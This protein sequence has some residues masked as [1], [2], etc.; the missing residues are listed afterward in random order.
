MKTFRTIL[1]VTWKELAL[2]ARD[3]GNL[4]IMFLLPLLLSVM[5]SAANSSVNAEEGVAAI[6]LHVALV[7][8]D[9]GDFGREVVNAVEAIDELDIQRFVDL[10]E[11]EAE[12]AEGELSAAIH[13]PADFSAS[14]NAY[15]PTQVTVIVDPAQPESASIV[16]GIMNQVVDEVTIWGEVQ[17]GIRSVF[18]ESGILDNI[19]PEERRG[20]EAM[21]LGVIMT[22]LGEMR[23]SPLI[24]VISEDLEGEVSEDWL[25]AFLAYIFSG[26]VVMFI[27]F[28]VPMTSES[29]LKEREVGTLRRLIAAPIPATSVITGKL[30]AYMVLPCLQAILLFGVASIFFGVWLG[31]SPIALVVLTLIT[32]ATAASFGL[33]IASFAKSASQAANLGTAAGFILAIVAG[34]VPIGS[35]AFTRTGGFISILARIAPQAHALEGYLKLLSDGEGFVAILPELGILIAFTLVFLTISTRRFRYV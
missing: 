29:I 22:R 28:I 19:T 7:N 11:A 27:F 31:S 24:S 23:R 21:N 32:A 6:L 13:F 8:E 20:L 16:T 17:Y 14:I 5:Q 1:A 9:T 25:E 15:E 30:L 35:Q 34:A 18:D 3:R 2:I 10:K 26:Y 4:A 33:L 12:V